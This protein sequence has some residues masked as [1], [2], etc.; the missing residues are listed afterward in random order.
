LLN[1]KIYQAI[2]LATGKLYL[3]NEKVDSITKQ[4]PNNYTFSN[5]E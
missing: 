1:N 2:K 4:S 3:K 5:A